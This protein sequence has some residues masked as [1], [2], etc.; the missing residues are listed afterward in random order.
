MFSQDFLRECLD[1]NAD[2][3]IFTWKVRPVHHFTDERSSKSWNTKY[4]LKNAGFLNRVTGY[5]CLLINGKNIRLHRAAFFITHGY[6]P[7]TVD[8]ING[9][10]TDNRICNLREATISQNNMNRGMQSNNTSGI[11]GIDMASN[12]RWRARIHANGKEIHIGYFTTCDEA[13]NA[14]SEARNKYHGEF[15]NFSDALAAGHRNSKQVTAR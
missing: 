4:S 3:G 5:F 9:I 12:G 13:Y 1:Y 11:K 6:L 2:T 15:A 14:L 7:I 8:H 10:K